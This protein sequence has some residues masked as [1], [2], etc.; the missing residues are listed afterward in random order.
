MPAV[1]ELRHVANFAAGARIKPLGRDPKL[2]KD[3]PDAPAGE[4]L[5]NAAFA[6]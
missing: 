6:E 1:C 2:H 3:H 5:R 4:G